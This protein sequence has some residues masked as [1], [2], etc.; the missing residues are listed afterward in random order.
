MQHALRVVQWIVVVEVYLVLLA[1]MPID[2]DAVGFYRSDGTV[3]RGCVRSL[4]PKQF[5]ERFNGTTRRCD[6]HQWCFSVH[7]RNGLLDMP[8][9]HGSAIAAGIPEEGNQVARH[10][11]EL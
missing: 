8:A 5:L 4:P 6:L 7:E 11:E 1:I 2:N 9:G 3:R 10:V